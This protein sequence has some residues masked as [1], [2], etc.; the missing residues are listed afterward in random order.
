MPEMLTVLDVVQRS[1]AFL[2]SKGVESARL[3]AEWLIASALGMDRMK[4][5][6]QFDR[7]L[8]E[9]ELADMRSKVARRAKREPL[10]YILGSTPFHELDLKVDRRALIPRPET[11]QLVELALG[12]FGENDVAYRI[13]DLGTGSGAIALALAFALPRA[14]LFAVDASREALGLAQENALGCGLQN[15]VT[16]ILSDWF[17]DFDVEGEF[18]L[19][20]SNPPYLTEEEMGSAEPEV[21][22]YEPHSALFAEKQ[23]LSDL[24]KIVQG[25]FERLR[26]GGVLWLET[27]V[28]HRQPLADLCQSLGYASVEGVDDWS[29][30][31]RFVKAV[32]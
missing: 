3:N 1:A 32:K 25:S 5:Y 14:E 31:P 17:S 9:S 20:V 15:R 29:G 21:K 24:E 28:K 27:G 26:A 12:S 23:G 8:K 2:E 10:Q 4:L 30:R 18:D 7:P 6:L 13:V 16:F 11:E 19:I 22:D